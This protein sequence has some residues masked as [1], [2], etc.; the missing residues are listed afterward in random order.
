LRSKHPGL[1]GIFHPRWKVTHLA[2]A[3][4]RARPRVR[5]QG[6]SLSRRMSCPPWMAVS[7]R[8][9]RTPDHHSAL[10]LLLLLPMVH[11]VL[12]QMGL[13]ILLLRVLLRVTR[14]RRPVGHGGW[15]ARYP[16]RP[17]PRRRVPLRVHVRLPARIDLPGRRGVP[18]PRPQDARASHITSRDPSGVRLRA[19]ASP[20]APTP[21]TLRRV[22]RRVRRMLVHGPLGSPT[23]RHKRQSR[24][25]LPPQTHS[26]AHAA[27]TEP[28]AYASLTPPPATPARLLAALKGDGAKQRRARRP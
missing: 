2:R 16:A 28:H 26:L 6:A 27:S 22:L 23:T 15:R 17:S 7:R 4:S 9:G 11:H 10:L 1:D 5:V 25:T 8:G 12:L 20:W 3:N 14:K 24:V 19:T 21:W 13:R 18:S